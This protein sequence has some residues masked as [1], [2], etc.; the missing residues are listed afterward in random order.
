M[1]ARIGSAYK[2]PPSMFAKRTAA[3]DFQHFLPPMSADDEA[4]QEA[5]TANRR[6]GPAVLRMEY[7]R[8]LAAKRRR[9]W[10][11]AWRASRGWLMVVAVVV[12]AVFFVNR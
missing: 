1:K 11:D 8:L 9:Q 7:D 6:K 2:V 12:V 3:G 10:A 4:V 5:M